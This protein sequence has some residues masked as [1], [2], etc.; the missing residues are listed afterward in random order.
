MGEVLKT[1]EKLRR[2]CENHGSFLN[3]KKNEMMN[4]FPR[5]STDIVNSSYQLE[6]IQLEAMK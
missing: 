4:V 2:A 3:C 5:P 6:N 1:S